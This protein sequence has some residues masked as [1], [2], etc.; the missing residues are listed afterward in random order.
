MG[1]SNKIVFTATFVFA[2][3]ITAC[4]VYFQ[5]AHSISVLQPMLSVP[6][7]TGM[8]VPVGS[9]AVA[10]SNVNTSLKQHYSTMSPHWRLA[11]NRVPKAGSTYL[12]ILLSRLK[13]WNHFKIED[14]SN[15]HPSK[16]VLSK[17]LSQLRNNTV[18][19]NHA[20]FLEEGP[21][22]LMWINIVREPLARWSS[23]FYY[24]VDPSKREMRAAQSL[25]QRERDVRCGCAR[26]EFDECIKVRHAHDCKMNMPSQMAFFCEPGANCSR[27]IAIA[28]VKAKYA[29]VGLTEELPLTL[30]LLELLVP[31]VFKNATKAAHSLPQKSKH[32]TSLSNKATNTTMNGA[33]SD[34]SR[35]YIKAKAPNYLD[36][37]LFYEEVK[38]M[39]YRKAAE[40]GLLP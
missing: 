32:A 29:L 27:A 30:V 26:L 2:M 40:N 39:F 3:T 24:S 9:A 7:A 22:D 10:H 21:H 34:E 23:H 28:N 20:G 14:H 19:V 36:E 11:Y 16:Q 31:R 12:K 1:H 6:C 5:Q 17:E 33:L 37:H 35:A 25:R 13:R 15:Y 8:V 4:L 18:Y 38:L